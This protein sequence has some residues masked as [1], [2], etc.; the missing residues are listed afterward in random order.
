MSGREKKS[1]V[2]EKPEW[3]LLDDDSINTM[4]I[5]SIFKNRTNLSPPPHTRLKDC[6]GGFV[7]ETP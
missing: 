6:Q 5:D 1:P 2:W 4:F 3:Q 7:G